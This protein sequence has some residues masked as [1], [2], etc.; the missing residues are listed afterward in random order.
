[1]S[2]SNIGQ[3][4]ICFGYL[5]IFLLIGKILRVKIRLFQKLFLPSS[6]IGGF[7]ALLLGQ[8]VLGV[9]S[10]EVS[11]TWSAIPGN[12][13]NIIFA[14]MFIGA[15]IPKFR[16]VWSIAAAGTTYNY[17]ITSLQWLVGIGIATFIIAPIWNLPPIVGS[18]VEIGWAGGHG[19]AAGM[20]E[21]FES[22]GYPEIADLGTISAT[23]GLVFGIVMGIVLINYGVRKKYTKV[24]RNPNEI[25]REGLSGIVP[26]DKVKPFGRQTF[27]KFSIEPLAFHVSLVLIALILG[28]LIKQWLGAA[29]N[30]FNSIPLF[31]FAMIGGLII[32]LISKVVKVD[33]L[34]DKSTV[35]RIQG[36]A[37]DFLVVSAMATINLSVV[38]QYFVPLAILMIA[39]SIVMVVATLVVAPWFYPKDWFECAIGD[40]GTLCGVVAV[41]LML[42]KVVDPEFETAGPQVFAY[43]RPFV[44]P[45]TGGG[46][47]TSV[48]PVMI[49][50]MGAVNVILISVGV[51][52]A[53]I[54]VS[55]FCG[56]FSFSRTKT[57]S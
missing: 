32:Q 17:F 42:L 47:I 44:S 33:P 7:L 15:V 14:C 49:V 41:G 24:L 53:S 29:N 2:S 34:I 57:H 39:T 52:I 20:K 45:F 19:T 43:K 26:K 35:E 5:G 50:T 51:M 36:T 4:F 12:L 16:E 46:L 40:F 54:L 11:K 18:I 21:V 56:L 8:Y 38:A 6:L 22:F 37:L 28:Q 9:V 13:I 30:I 55:K 3:L 23:Y 10:P 48:I 25:S 1:M 31:P 27:E